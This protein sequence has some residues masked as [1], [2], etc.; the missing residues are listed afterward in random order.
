MRFLSDFLRLFLP[1]I[2][3]DFFPGFIPRFLQMFLPRTFLRCCGGFSSRVISGISSKS[4]F[5]VFFL[6]FD[7]CSTGVHSRISARR[8]PGIASTVPH[9]FFFR[10]SLFNFF[11]AYLQSKAYIWSS[12]Q[13]I[14][15]GMSLEVL[16]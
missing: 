3:T 15:R 5:Y 4:S 10:S 11:K 9:G 8:F 1:E 2:F 14:S 13:E 16:P 6:V 12:S 7:E